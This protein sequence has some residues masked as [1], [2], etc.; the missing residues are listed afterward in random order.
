MARGMGRWNGEEAV[1][2]G[3]A[4]RQQGCLMPTGNLTS[5]QG[6]LQNASWEHLLNMHWTPPSPFPPP[7]DAIMATTS[8]RKFRTPVLSDNRRI[9]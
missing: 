6:D 3:R 2:G 1:E 4:G 9:N 7:P 8:F 5:R